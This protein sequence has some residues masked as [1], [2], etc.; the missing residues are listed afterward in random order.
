MPEVR[1]GMV[2]RAT[3]RPPMTSPLRERLMRM[4]TIRGRWF[5]AASAALLVVAMASAG[6][7]QPETQKLKAAP[8]PV[9]STGR[10]AGKVTEGGKTPI[11][12]ASV[13]IPELKRGVPSDENG[14]FVLTDVPAGTYTLRAKDVGHGTLTQQV[15][16]KAGATVTVD[17]TFGEAKA[18]K[19]LEEIEVRAE[20][21]IDVKSSQTTHTID[22]AQLKA[23]PVDN[24]REAVATKAGVVAQGGELHFRGGRGNEVKIQFDGVEP[25][26]PLF[27]RGANIAN[28]AIAGTEIVTG[29]FDAE[30][31]NALSGIISVSTKEGTERLAGD[32]RWGTDR[33]GD[34]TKTF[35]NLDRISFGFGGPAPV[36]NLTYFAT[37]EGTFSDTYL[38]STLTKPRR[39]MFH[40]HKLR[41]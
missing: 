19:T 38:K 27:G 3:W 31:G 12:F 11:Q 34:P 16:V 35:D 7:S 21:R 23:L 29:G 9:A 18:V 32:V 36:K 25:T 39:T 33:Y 17:F 20:K 13:D 24:L 41:K 30:V 37:Y 2:N 6:F 4:F 22:A 1:I 10:I 5:G 14:K 15:T 8:P 28:L 26:D 40:F